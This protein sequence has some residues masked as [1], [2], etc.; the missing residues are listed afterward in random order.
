MKQKY[1]INFVCTNNLN[2]VENIDFEFT[3]DRNF[4]PSGTM[5]VGGVFMVI[6]DSVYDVAKDEAE[7]YAT[8]YYPKNKATDAFGEVDI[9]AAQKVTYDV[10]AMLSDKYKLKGTYTTRNATCRPYRTVIEKM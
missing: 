1:L 10:I 8:C 7:I 6:K 2:S 9:E 5:Y 3:V 4:L